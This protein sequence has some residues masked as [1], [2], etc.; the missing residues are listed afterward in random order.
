MIRCGTF[1][2]LL[3]A[4]IIVSSVQASAQP[5]DEARVRPLD[6]R[7]G[8]LEDRGDGIVWESPPIGY[9]PA[10]YIRLRFSDVSAA[11]R[12]TGYDVVVRDL[13]RRA[14]ARFAAAQ[15]V[16][17]QILY[18]GVLFA[19]RV[20]VSIEVRRGQPPP[21]GLRFRI[22]ELT[23]EIDPQMRPTLHGPTYNWNNVALFSAGDPKRSIAESVA[24]LYLG[25]D[26]EVASTCTG[27]LVGRDALLTNLHCLEK[28]QVYRESARAGADVSSLRCTDIAIQ[29]D[30][31]AVPQVSSEAQTS[32]LGVLDRDVGQRLDFALL[33]IAPPLTVE[34]GRRRFLKLAAEMPSSGEPAFVIH[35]PL[36][37]TLKVSEHCSAYASPREFQ[38]DHNCP[39]AAGSSG[40]P[41]LSVKSGR[42]IGLHRASAHKDNATIAETER[43][44]KEAE[45]KGLPPPRNRSTDSAALYKRLERFLQPTD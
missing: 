15:F 41:V 20:T 8:H 23:Y 44:E 40:A 39:T 2:G 16:G 14:I 30:Y 9:G 45:L 35:H 27:F 10:K 6:I 21:V 1:L 32:C 36:G 29:F 24:K 17:P 7:V 28:S 3:F 33:K 31:L 13:K 37:L 11:V 18:T 43:A 5:Y 22:D 12:E 26:R 25:R 34:G 38:L 42:V 19:N 4:A